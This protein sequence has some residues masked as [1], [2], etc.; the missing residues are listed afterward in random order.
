MVLA[1]SHSVALHHLTVN[2]SM[3]VSI[4][5]T[6]PT[7]CQSLGGTSP[8][9]L[10][11]ISGAP[12]TDCQSVNGTPPTECQSIRDT[13][14]MIYQSINHYSIFGLS[15]NQWYSSH[16]LSIIQWYSIH[17]YW[18]PVVGALLIDG[19]SVSG[20]TVG[21]GY[22]QIPPRTYP[23]DPSWRNP[24]RGSMSP[25]ETIK[26][27][28]KAALE[29]IWIIVFGSSTHHLCLMR[30]VVFSM[31]AYGSFNLHFVSILLIFKPS[32]FHFMSFCLSF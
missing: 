27:D 5:G 8:Y 25:H 10:S 28:D 30:F 12:P 14:L 3:V 32:D 20:A 6:P 1:I 11:S 9:W 22:W 15:I 21:I 31:T 17:W 26:M 19:D 18:Q 16:D 23:D 7:D 29:E 13:S 4:Y 24:R 2:Q